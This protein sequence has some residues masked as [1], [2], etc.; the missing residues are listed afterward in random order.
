MQLGRDGL[1]VEAG[2]DERPQG[3]GEAAQGLV[4]GPSDQGPYPAG[5][6]DVAGDLV[7]RATRPSAV[8]SPAAAAA[9]GGVLRGRAVRARRASRGVFQPTTNL[10]LLSLLVPTR[11]RGIMA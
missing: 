5:D 8:A 10:N 7:R 1:R 4:L 11:R 9:A 2:V 6:G 3:E